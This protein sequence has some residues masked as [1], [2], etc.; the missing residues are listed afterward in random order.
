MR[1]VISALAV[2]MGLAAAGCA[3]KEAAL[4]DG[5]SRQENALNAKGRNAVP[6]LFYQQ[7]SVTGN[8]Y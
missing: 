5:S 3:S 2:V 4:A 1:I 6:A 7:Y 8:R